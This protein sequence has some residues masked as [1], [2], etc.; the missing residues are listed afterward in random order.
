M[1]RRLLVGVFAREVKGL[2][3]LRYILAVALLALLLPQVSSAQMLFL[4]AFSSPPPGTPVVT[5]SLSAKPQLL[6]RIEVIEPVAITC[7]PFAYVSN[8][9]SSSSVSQIQNG[10]VVSINGVLVETL[11]CDNVPHS[12]HLEASIPNGGTPWRVGQAVVQL[13][14]TACGEQINNYQYVCVTGTKSRTV[15]LP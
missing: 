6:D 5:I 12:Y 10:K 8:L 7:G 15:N 11:A 1:V 3:R 2:G 13:N 9:Y 14:V 4:T